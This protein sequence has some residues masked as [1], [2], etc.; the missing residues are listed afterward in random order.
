MKYTKS[1]LNKTDRFC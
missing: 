1:T